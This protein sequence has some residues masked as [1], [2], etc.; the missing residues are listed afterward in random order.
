MSGVWLML[1]QDRPKAYVLASGEMH[2]VRE[3]LDKSLEFAG[4]EFVS[5]GSED[6]EKYF[7][8][9]GQLIFEVNPKFY[10]PAE[11]HK[12]CGDCRLQNKRWV[13]FVKLA[14][15]WSRKCT[16]TIT[17]SYLN[18]RSKSCC[19]PSRDGRIIRS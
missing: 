10:R 19:R 13:G 9:D 5:K 17:S 3:F 14:K 6:E 2:S 1:N 8:K 4:I 11:V 16:K 7:T 15:V 12:L 18:D